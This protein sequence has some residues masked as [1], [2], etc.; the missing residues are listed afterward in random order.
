MFIV[1]FK[2]GDVVSILLT[3]V[4]PSRLRQF[5]INEFHFISGFSP[6]IPCRC[7]TWLYFISWEHFI[8]SSVCLV[9]FHLI[10]FQSFYSIPLHSIPFH[11]I[12]SHPIP[13][14]SFSFHSISIHFSSSSSRRRGRTLV[15]PPLSTT[16]SSL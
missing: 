15:G 4:I 8:F 10:L 14:H 1:P 5:R 3:Y 11:S 12:P 16:S 7:F 6:S 13:F 2:V 9:Y